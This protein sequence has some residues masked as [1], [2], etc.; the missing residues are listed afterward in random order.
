MSKI[1]I[2]SVCVFCG[3]SPGNDPC[4]EREARDLGAL[5]AAQNVSLVFG[6]GNAGIMG[7][8]ANTVLAGGGEVIG[9][10]PDYLVEREHAHKE[11]TRL[12][13]VGSMHERK[14]RMFELSDGFI[15]LPGGVGTLEETFEVITWKQLGM[16]AKPIIILNTNGYWSKLNELVA[17]TVECEFAAPPTLDLYTM[18]DSPEEALAAVRE[19]ATTAV[20]S[21]SG[22]L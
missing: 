2:Q 9:V 17:A 7:A 13:V 18:V 16:H 1:G 22:R 12:D 15:A 10:I 14:R 20:P 5:L 3:A 21:D 19:Q 11:V 4:Y 6:G 8:I